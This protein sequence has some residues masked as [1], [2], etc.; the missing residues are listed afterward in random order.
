[1]K[2]SLEKLQK[3]LMT[4]GNLYKEHAI[5]PSAKKLNKARGNL[6][7]HI[8]EIGQSGDLSLIVA[9]EKAIVT[10]ELQNHAN[11]PGMVSSLGAALAELDAT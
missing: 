8:E 4:E 2:T 10:D 6:L 1:M 3:F 9:A 5:A 11:S 7:A